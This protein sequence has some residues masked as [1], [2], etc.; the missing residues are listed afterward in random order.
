MHVQSWVLSQEDQ[1]APEDVREVYDAMIAYNLAQVGDHWRGRL[2]IFARDL[3][4]HILGAIFGYTDR[5]W[6]RVEMLLVKDGWRGQGMG[7]HL[8]AAAEAEARARGCHDAWL[9][10]YSFQALPFYQK[11]GYVVFGK[12]EHYPAEHSRYFV[13]KSLSGPSS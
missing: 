6:L 8:L 1:P 2:T 10:T 4:N 7:A 3:Q 9:E 5:G 11:Q 13:R 12:L